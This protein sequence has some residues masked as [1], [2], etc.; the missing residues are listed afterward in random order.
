M[1]YLSFFRSPKNP[2]E[3]VVIVVVAVVVINGVVYNDVD[4]DF[5]ILRQMWALSDSSM[6]VNR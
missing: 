2:G 1:C 5:V 3:R 4:K 6:T